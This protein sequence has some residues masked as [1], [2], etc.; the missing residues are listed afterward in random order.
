METISELEPKILLSSVEQKYYT[1]ELE[2]LRIII[3][4]C[5]NKCFPLGF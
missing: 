5:N 4:I 3:V 2:V 1:L